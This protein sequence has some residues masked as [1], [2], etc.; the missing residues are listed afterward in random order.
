MAYFDIALKRD[1]RI[2]GLVSAADFSI[3]SFISDI[4]CFDT[5]LYFSDA[6]PK[7][8]LMLMAALYPLLSA[9]LI[10][11]PV[12][13]LMRPADSLKNKIFYP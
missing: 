7:S 2:F 9:K 11:S 6:L 13:G 3:F 12:L 4:S 8:A 10:P 1:F 5:S